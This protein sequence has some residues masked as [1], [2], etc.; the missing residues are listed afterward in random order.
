MLDAPR[1]KAASSY[2]REIPIRI[3]TPDAGWSVQIE[4]VYLKDG[5]T[6]VH[7]ALTRTSHMA[8]QVV[9]TVT[10]SI[11]VDLPESIA[12]DYCI[13]CKTWDWGNATLLTSTQNQN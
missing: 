1:N 10:D 11:V 3:D 5:K 6:I 4:G 8:A 12:M 2:G 7:A 13:S 9:T